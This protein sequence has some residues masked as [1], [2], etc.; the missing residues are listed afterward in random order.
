MPTAGTKRPFRSRVWRS[1]G[2]AVRLAVEAVA[3]SK[4]FFS[5]AFTGLTIA[6]AAGAACSSSSGGDGDPGLPARFEAGAEASTADAAAAESCKDLA[7]V[8]GEP[9]ACDQ[10]VKAKCCDSVLACTKSADCTA[11]QE[12]IAPCAQ[13]DFICI[14]TCTES[15]PRGTE[16]LQ[17]IG[18]CAKTN[19]KTECASSEPPDSGGFDTGL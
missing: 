14:S 15:H 16:I 9:K 1:R 13:D 18:S 19:C 12:C 6:A 7:L 11:V 8:V 10:C 3:L 2:D 17:E 4:F 5:V